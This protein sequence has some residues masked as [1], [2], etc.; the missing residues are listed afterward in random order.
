MQKLRTTFL[1]GGRHRTV[2]RMLKRNA[3]KAVQRIREYGLDKRPSKEEYPYGVTL[4]EKLLE[5]IN[6]SQGHLQGFI[7]RNHA[8]AEVLNVRNVMFLD[9]DTPIVYAP[10]GGCLFGLLAWIGRLFGG[11]SETAQLGKPVN[12]QCRNLQTGAVGYEK[13]NSESDARTP[14]VWENQYPWAATQELGAF[15]S[16]ASNKPEWGVRIYKTAAGYRGIVTHALFDP[17]DPET[18]RLMEQFACDPQYVRLCKRQESFRARITP[19]GWRCGLWPDQL[20]Q[21]F[22]FKWPFSSNFLFHLRKLVKYM[23]LP[24]HSVEEFIKRHEKYYEAQKRFAR[25]DAVID[26]Q[27]AFSLYQEHYDMAEKIYEE[28]SAPFATCRYLGTVGSEFVHPE[29]QA[30]LDIHDEATRAFQSEELTL[31]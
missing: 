12:P 7:T 25:K 26:Y 1:F 5:E 13:L 9:W 4:R 17:T 14:E 20:P 22:Q 3:R 15:M 8:G 21:H 24:D 19:K 28:A 11:K 2:S 10:L 16:Y 27:E 6:D 31:A 18:L 23:L 30:I 29:V